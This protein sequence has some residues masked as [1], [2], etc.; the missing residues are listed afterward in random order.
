MSEISVAAKWPVF[1]PSLKNNV[2]NWFLYSVEKEGT[3][4]HRLLQV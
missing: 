2:R 4:E 3:V 1:I